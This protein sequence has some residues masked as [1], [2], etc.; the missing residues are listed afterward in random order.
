MAL[1]YP[2]RD[3]GKL[4]RSLPGAHAGFQLAKHRVPVAASLG[5]ID[6]GHGTCAPIAERHAEPGSM[7]QFRAG[8]QDANNLESTSA[9]R[10]D[11]DPL[12]YDASISAESFLP[13]PIADNNMALAHQMV[14]LF[15]QEPS[16]ERP[17]A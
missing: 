15:A 5:L 3:A 17:H 2:A 6:S 10:V 1:G 13:V 12:T 16:E 9:K 11:M 4:G 7:R 14:I 8:W